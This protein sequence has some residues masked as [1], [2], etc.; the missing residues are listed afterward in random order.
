MAFALHLP[1]ALSGLS[2]RPRAPPPSRRASSAVTRAN[3]PGARFKLEKKRLDLCRARASASATTATSRP[4][5][6]RTTSPRPSRERAGVRPDQGRRAPRAR[7]ANRGRR[8]A[9]LIRRRR[10]RFVVAAR[11]RGRAAPARLAGRAARRG[12]RL[13]RAHD[14]RA[15][16]AARRPRSRPPPTRRR[17][18]ADSARRARCARSRCATRAS[19]PLRSRGAARGERPPPPPPR[20]THPPT[21]PPTVSA[22]EPPARARPLPRCRRDPAILLLTC[23]SCAAGFWRVELNASCDLPRAAFGCSACATQGHPLVRATIPR[24]GQQQWVGVRGGGGRCCVGYAVAWCEGAEAGR[25]E[26]RGR[27]ARRA[28]A[29]SRRARRAR[30]SAST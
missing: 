10:R 14:D 21:H 24:R 20:A 5:E 27:D 8:S 9:S 4:G 26:N 28:S 23:A 22:G 1:R 12:R 3:S 7:A 6:G 25:P 29:P 18:R 16:R 30:W 15:R 2:P 19:A 11:A 13:G 17:T